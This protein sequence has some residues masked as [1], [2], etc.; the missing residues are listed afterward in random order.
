MKLRNVLV[1]CL[2]N[3]RLFL[4]DI[5]SS[6]LS[7]GPFFLHRKEQKP[8]P[9]YV[10]SS[11]LGRI[12]TNNATETTK[13]LIRALKT[14]KGSV[15]V[16]KRKCVGVCWEPFLDTKDSGCF[17]FGFLLFLQR[18]RSSG[19]SVSVSNIS[20]FYNIVSYLMKQE[21]DI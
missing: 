18:Q 2:E 13:L 17:L 7:N 20:W 6:F 1:F 16:C 5:Y 11:V 12:G 4:A 10:C 21:I 8:R 19:S 14:N 3:L 9:K 15:K